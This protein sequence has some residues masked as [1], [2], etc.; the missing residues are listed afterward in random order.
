M[1]ETPQGER[2]EVDPIAQG[3]NVRN[4]LDLVNRQASYAQSLAQPDDEK[5]RR[6]FEV[7][8]SELFK[9]F[10]GALR[11]L[12]DDDPEAFSHYEELVQATI[13]ENLSEIHSSSDSY[14]RD[15]YTWPLQGPMIMGSTTAIHNECKEYAD[16]ITHLLPIVQQAYENR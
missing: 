9:N 1:I 3:R 5:S 10:T 14:I 7:Y 16:R 4:L 6:F 11:V 8:H 2:W 13:R 15:T 12:H